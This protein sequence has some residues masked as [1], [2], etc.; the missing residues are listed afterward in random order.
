MTQKNK[1]KCNFLYVAMSI[2]TSH[3]LKFVY[4]TK[5][6]RLGY[7]ENET[8]FQNEKKSLIK[9]QGLRYDKKYF[10]SGGTL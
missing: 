9:H 4:F 2:M 5:T 7:L 3:I 10:C 6:Q 1:H 8:F